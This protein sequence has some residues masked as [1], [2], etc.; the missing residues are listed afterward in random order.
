MA[1]DSS[2]PES[3]GSRV[4]AQVQQALQRTQAF[5]GSLTAEDVSS[6]QWFIQL[7]QRVAR[8]YDRNARAAYFQRK[9]RG[10][11]PDA[12]ADRLR[13]VVSRYAAIAGGVTG[14][15]VTANQVLALPSAGATLALATSSIGAEMF[16]LCRIQ[17]R[18]ILDLATLY[19]QPVDPDDPEDV[20][21]IF[22]I[23]L[24]VA[25]ASAVGK[26]A[27][28]AAGHG[29][30]TA[31]RKVISKGTLKAIQDVGRVFG[32][33]I[34]QRTIIKYSVP[35][36]S[37]AM[38]STYNYVT[39]QS[40]GRVA[41]A[42]FRTRGQAAQELRTHLAGGAAVA[43][44][45]LPAAMMAMAMADGSLH[46]SEVTLYRAQLAQLD[47]DAD[48]A[49]VFDRLL[50]DRTFL[51]DALGEIEDL[52]ARSGVVEALAMM[53]AFDGSLSEAEVVLLTDIAARLGVDL[54][55]DQVSRR[56]TKYRVDSAAARLTANAR[57][58]AERV[59]GGARAGAVAARDAG[60][61]LMGRAAE[62][63]KGVWKGRRR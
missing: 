52:D 4:P 54:D 18:L 61:R 28:Q 50:H 6:G 29:S 10:L 46:A 47:P 1:T 13:S 55:I 20:L 31:V 36:A 44:A 60:G 62:V 33:K 21:A 37:A 42:Q 45:V 43:G 32:L 14:A 40:F 12:I 53:A 17:M 7:L 5:A 56:A 63:S 3:T 49:A 58:A 35:V 19:D 27:Q 25:P 26:L 41:Q 9:Y 16:Y 22:G 51:L 2:T 15:T 11:P 39:T 48:D 24:G 38:G 23:A 8:T 59:G 30:R 34:L 57:A